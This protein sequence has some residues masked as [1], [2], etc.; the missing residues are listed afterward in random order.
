MVEV[1]WTPSIQLIEDITNT[2][3]AVVTTVDDFDFEDGQYV[4]I[5]V[6]PIYGMRLS[7]ARTKI[8][9]LSENTF[10]TDLDLSAQAA[11]SPP[12]SGLYTPANVTEIT[13]L[14]RNSTPGGPSA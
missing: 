3:D 14:Y 5:N 2:V 7:N 12:L 8:D 1:I 6:D 11:F 9:I 4:L 13:G 10:R